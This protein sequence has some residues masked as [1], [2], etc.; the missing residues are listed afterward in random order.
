M[1]P[2]FHHVFIQPKTKGLR[3]FNGGEKKDESSRLVSENTHRLTNT[4][5]DGTNAG[6]TPLVIS[7]VSG[8]G[9]RSRRAHPGK[10]QSSGKGCLT[11]HSMTKATS[12]MA[13]L[14]P[15]LCLLW[16]GLFLCQVGLKRFHPGGQ[17]EPRLKK[18]PTHNH[19]NE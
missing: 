1:L 18:A 3:D 13:P 17:M 15:S 19:P 11:L 9:W 14:W 5:D 6:F 10:L 12:N 16:A 2:P 4:D 8:S 7:A